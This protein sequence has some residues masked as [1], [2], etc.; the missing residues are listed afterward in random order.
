MA[1]LG[2]QCAGSRADVAR[3]IRSPPQAMRGR[4]G[5][6]SESVR[7]TVCRAESENLVKGEGFVVSKDKKAWEKPQTLNFRN[8]SEAIEYYSK[9][10]TPEHVEAIKQLFNNG[11]RAREHT[12]QKKK[13]GSSR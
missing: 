13:A 4:F 8:V 12:E 11:L 3:N 9:H 6:T 10:G 2:I 7:S 1:S 5:C